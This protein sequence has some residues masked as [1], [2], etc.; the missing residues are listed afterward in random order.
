MMKRIKQFQKEV[1]EK[2][3]MLGNNNDLTPVLLLTSYC[4]DKNS[5]CTNIKPCDECLKM[6][7]IAFIEKSAISL[8]N[9]ICGFD[10]IKNI[11]EEE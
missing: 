6:C 7:N 11:G 1:E 8:D 2:L 5:N 9:V 10:F 4:G 3:H